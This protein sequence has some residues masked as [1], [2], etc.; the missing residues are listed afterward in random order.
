[1][2]PGASMSCLHNSRYLIVRRLDFVA[3]K[4]PSVVDVSGQNPTMALTLPMIIAVE[5]TSAR[6]PCRSGVDRL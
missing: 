2:S 6:A 3:R 1:M 5:A 4:R